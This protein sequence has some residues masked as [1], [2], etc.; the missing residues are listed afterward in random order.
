MSQTVAV[1]TC[2][3]R[4]PAKPPNQTYPCDIELSGAP[5]GAHWLLVPRSLD[6]R[7][8]ESTAIDKLELIRTAAGVVYLGAYG[9]PGFYALRLD[10]GHLRVPDWR[11][12]T[13]HDVRAG[14]L[15]L[16]E[17]VDLS[18]GGTLSSLAAGSLAPPS[19]ATSGAALLNSWTPPA[20]S[21]A[22]IRVTERHPF[23]LTPPP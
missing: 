11:F 16:A 6:E 2:H 14:E 18:S 19:T 15:W 1:V 13:A 9:E 20:G 4:S 7:L 21:R 23:Q 8:V 5:A 12:T 22:T 10:G 3:A 17:D